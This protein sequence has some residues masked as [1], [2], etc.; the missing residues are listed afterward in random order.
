MRYI[1]ILLF[2]GISV[3]IGCTIEE[4]DV[5]D[6]GSIFISAE[7]NSGAPLTGGT[8][9]LDGV[10]M[11]PAPDTLENV[12]VGEHIV[13]IKITGYDAEED[14]LMVVKNQ[15]TINNFVL[16][17]A[18]FA[19]LNWAL[20]TPGAAIV[21][22]RVMLDPAAVMPLQVDAGLHSVSAFLNGNKT[23]TPALYSLNISPEDTESV[24]FTFQAGTLGNT[25]GMIAPDFER[26][27]DYLDTL[28]LHDYRGYIVMLT[29]YY[30]NCGPCMAE[31]PDIDQCYIDYAPYGV[32]V[33]GVNPMNPDDLADVAQ[34]RSNLNIH[35]K[36]LS[37]Y[38]YSVNLM[39]GIT[40]FP[41]NII[42]TPGGEIHTRMYS[43]NYADLSALFDDILGL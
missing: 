32:Q 28:S 10:P 20:G 18:A 14:T 12:I 4:S 5:P 23:L 11:Q 36:L 9:Y 42:I 29:F 21:V 17:P 40:Q 37:D 22:D 6:T 31:F 3:F 2:F 30:S 41:T 1:Q 25:V 13:R 16:T 26:T 35:F 7:D 15:V 34:V 33:W 19:Y 39:Y 24:S 43:T 38:G 27:D 8:I